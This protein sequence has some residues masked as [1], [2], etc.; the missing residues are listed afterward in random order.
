MSDSD[1][2]YEAMDPRIRDLATW[3]WVCGICGHRN[4]EL[5]DRHASDDACTEH[6][7]EHEV[8]A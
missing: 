6:M 2:L 8:H 3:T 5:E 4:E 7:K 1:E